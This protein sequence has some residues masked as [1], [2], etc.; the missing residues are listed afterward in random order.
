MDARGQSPWWAQEEGDSP[1]STLV[2]QP[3]GACHPSSPSESQPVSVSLSGTGWAVSLE[4]SSPGREPRGRTRWR[5]I[6]WGQM[7]EMGRQGPSAA[8]GGAVARQAGWW[9]RVMG[10]SEGGRGRPV[11]QA[12]RGP[13]SCVWWGDPALVF[14]VARPCLSLSGPWTAHATLSRGPRCAWLLPLPVAAGLTPD[15]APPTWSWTVTARARFPCLGPNL[16]CLTWVASP[17]E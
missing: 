5:P 4:S 12:S 13:P 14:L 6:C 17:V 2:Q 11:S 7:E 15:P 10:G 9:G 8:R 3:W 16:S 1:C